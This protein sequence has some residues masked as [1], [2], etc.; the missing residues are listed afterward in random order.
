MNE[1]ILKFEVRRARNGLV[2]NVEGPHDEEGLN[3][4]VYQ[5]RYEDEV[6]GFADFLRYLNE[7]FG[8]LTSRYDPKRIHIRIEPG[9]KFG[10]R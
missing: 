2:L 1:Y 3:E 7:E 5:E 9:D 10:D 6:E 8:P 4:I